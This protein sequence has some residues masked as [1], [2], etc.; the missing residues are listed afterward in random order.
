MKKKVRIFILFVLIF[1]KIII[2]LLCYRCRL[3]YRKV[4][5]KDTLIMCMNTARQ[6]LGGEK[7]VKEHLESMSYGVFL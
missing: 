6:G 5:L 2:R 3:I 1:V 7:R 4:K